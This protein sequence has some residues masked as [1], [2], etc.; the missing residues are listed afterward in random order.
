MLKGIQ[1]S[2]AY[3]NQFILDGID[4]EVEPNTTHCLMG[5]SGSGKSTLL[6]ILSGLIKP[7]KG[8]VDTDQKRGYVAQDYQLFPHMTVLKNICYAPLTLKVDKKASIELK[9]QELLK[10]LGLTS[11]Q[12]KLPHQLSGGQKQRVAIARC[13]MLSP[14]VLLMDEPTSALDPASIQ[15]LTQLIEIIQQQKIAVIIATHDRQFA[16]SVGTHLWSVKNRMLTC[17][18][19]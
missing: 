13:L 2:H 1:I 6:K 19:T 3:E 12:D 16:K 9:A 11:H 15:Q 7:T 18:P 10:Q 14:K 5:P 4:I 17:S 8:F